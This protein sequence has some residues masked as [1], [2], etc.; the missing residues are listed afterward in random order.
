M[1]EINKLN[2]LTVKYERDFKNKEEIIQ[3]EIGSLKQRINEIS[4]ECEKNSLKINENITYLKK[5]DETKLNKENEFKNIQQDRENIALEYEKKLNIHN[6][7]LAKINSLSISIKN[8][9]QNKDKL[10]PKVKNSNNELNLEYQS[11]LKKNEK[12]NVRL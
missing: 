4:S 9:D 1:D 6:D 10:N 8:F 7:I 12:A 11:I 5:L 3:N 2:D